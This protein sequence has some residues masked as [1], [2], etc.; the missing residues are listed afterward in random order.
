MLGR[1]FRERWYL[2]LAKT[3]VLTGLMILTELGLGY[4]AAAWIEH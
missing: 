2:Q 1:I 4:A 3:V